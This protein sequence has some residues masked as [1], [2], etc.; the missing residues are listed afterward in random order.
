MMGTVP[1]TLITHDICRKCNDEAMKWENEKTWKVFC[2]FIFSK[3]AM[4]SDRN[5]ND[6][7]DF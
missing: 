1:T 5:S 2:R 4:L 7:Y 3:I 6:V